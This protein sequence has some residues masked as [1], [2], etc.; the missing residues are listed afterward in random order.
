MIGIEEQT[1]AYET[2]V[3]DFRSKFFTNTAERLESLVPQY[4]ETASFLS[5]H[6]MKKA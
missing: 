1:A 4:F 6:A 5:T 3:I 2:E